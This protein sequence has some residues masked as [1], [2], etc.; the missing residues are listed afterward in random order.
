MS[1]LSFLVGKWSGQAHLQR[2]AGEPLVLQQKEEAQYKLDGLVLTIEG[3]GRT[4]NDDKPVLQALGIISYDD[5]TG[6]YH[7]RAFNDGRFL[8]SEVKLLEDGKSLSWGFGFGEIRSSSVLKINEKG[9]WTEFSEI[10]IG[11]QPAR[12][13]MDLTVRRD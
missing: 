10:H 9:E 8:E 6:T 5:D 13:L 12:K 2:G 1:K 11:S 4:A 7:L 3:I